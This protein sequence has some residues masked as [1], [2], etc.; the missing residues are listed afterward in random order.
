MARYIDADKFDTY[1]RLHNFPSKIMYKG[2][3]IYDYLKEY[4]DNE[5]KDGRENVYG[6]WI[7]F[8]NY[9][10]DGSYKCS[11]CGCE[12]LEDHLE[13]YKSKYC[14]NCGADMEVT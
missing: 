2:K 14:P 3:T 5:V 6:K 11:E 10:G 9:V 8:E 12:A 4:T 13:A 7:A 1:L